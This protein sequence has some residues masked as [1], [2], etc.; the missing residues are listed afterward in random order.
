M[1][2]I[3]ACSCVVLSFVVP[4]PAW[5]AVVTVDVT[6]KTVNP[7]SRGLTV[8]YMAGAEEKT[9]ELDVS[10]KAEI[11]VNGKEGTLTSL[12]PG[13]KAQVS[14]DKDL[15][16][17]TK[18]EAVG[19]MALSQE[20]CRFTLQVSEVG[21]AILRIERTS[22][23]PED[24][25]RGAPLSLSRWPH[26][27]ATK[28]RDGIFRFAHDFRDADDL[29][30]LASG[31]PPNVSLDRE[32]G[33]LTFTPG[34]LPEWAGGKLGAGFTY[35]KR[36]RLPLSV[37]ADI[38]TFGGGEFYISV[39]LLSQPVSVLSGKIISGEEKLTVPFKVDVSWTVVGEDRRG[40]SK[41]DVTKLIEESS[42]SLDRPF[43]KKFRLPLPSAT[44]TE[45]CNVS[46]GMES[47]KKPTTVSRLEMQ[48]RTAPAFGIELNEK[49]T[50]VFAKRVFEK[51]LGEMAG[52]QAGDILLA[53]NGKK[54]SS[55]KEALEM[56]SRLPIGE[57]VTLAVS[58]ANRM[59]KLSVVAE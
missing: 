34:R 30:T 45:L 31:E 51:S 3:A 47:G 55:M 9:I 46:L 10:R 15:A 48:G 19:T 52:I 2:L 6:L 38:N 58:R 59:Q 21:D 49:E 23:V 20:V 11:T 44:I 50:V 27:K 4:V 33:V 36:Q 54:P 32:L 5:A 28:G 8:T 56:L 29:K 39:F 40:R 1:R 42:V 41:K 18:V 37:S 17:V 25:F 7:Q 35:G 53:V 12:G 13:M 26:T 22:T 57:K 14:Y 24:T 43:E 16:V